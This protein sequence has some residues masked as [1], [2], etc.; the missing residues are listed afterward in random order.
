MSRRDSKWSPTEPRTIMDEDE[1]KEEGKESPLLLLL[2]LSPPEV[3]SAI[4][5]SSDSNFLRC[6]ERGSR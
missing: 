3:A 5:D 6:R 1:E 4:A 2:L